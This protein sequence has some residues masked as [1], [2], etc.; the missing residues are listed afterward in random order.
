MRLLLGHIVM[1]RRHAAESDRKGR[2]DKAPMSIDEVIQGR[3]EASR[4][5]SVSVRTFLTWRHTSHNAAADSAQIATYGSDAFGLET[6][7]R[8]SIWTHFIASAH[9][10]NLTHIMIFHI[11]MLS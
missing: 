1:T 5:G 11:E 3:V 6:S 10:W 2:D 7:G 8:S 4:T 9:S